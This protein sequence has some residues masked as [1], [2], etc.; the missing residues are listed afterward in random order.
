MIKGTAVKSTLSYIR[1]RLG[2]RES[3]F[4]AT[5]PEEFR[6]LM[7]QSILVSG[8]Y[9]ALGV[10]EIMERCAN[11]LGVPTGKFYLE[12]GQASAD[13]GLNTVYRIFLKLGSPEYIIKKAPLVWRSYYSQGN[14]EV[15]QSSPVTATVRIVDGDL[16][17]PAICGRIEG[18][19]ART[20]E[21]SG[22][23]NVA[24]THVRCSFKGD[25]CEEWKGQWQL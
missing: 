2:N 6:P 20:M 18:W 13:F 8:Y 17:H 16:P 9:E 24:M 10:G 22:G 7:T 15:L 19:M 12:C 25:D 21:L 14:F 5:L 3:E 1:E 4:L 11:F 23:K